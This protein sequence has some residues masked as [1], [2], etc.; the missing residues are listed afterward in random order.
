VQ[1][2]YN[3][4]SKDIVY[5]TLYCYLFRKILARISVNIFAKLKK[6]ILSNKSVSEV[7]TLLLSLEKLLMLELTTNA[8]IKIELLA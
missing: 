7:C 2:Y 3:F 6:Y 8:N 4:Q 1:F 5:I